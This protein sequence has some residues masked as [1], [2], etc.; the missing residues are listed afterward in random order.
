MKNKIQCERD[1]VGDACAALKAAYPDAT[2]M[3]GDGLRLDWDDRWVQ[4]RASN[5]EPILRVIAEAKGSDAA[6]ALCNSA[7]DVVRAAVE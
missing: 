4:V 1:R 5:T 2:A 7:M 3:D 6:T